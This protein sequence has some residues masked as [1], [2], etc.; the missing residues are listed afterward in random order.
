MSFLKPTF[1]LGERKDIPKKVC[2]P[3]KK[4][5]FFTGL[6]YGSSQ[7][8]VILPPGD[9]WQYLGISLIVKLGE[10]SVMLLTSSAQ[11][12]GLLFNILECAE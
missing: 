4:R 6:V 10:W 5:A 9:I 2:E 3:V 11:R 7:Q 1:L 8:E 12:T